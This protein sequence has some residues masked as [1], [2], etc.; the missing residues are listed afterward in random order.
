MEKRKLIWGS[1]K[2]FKIVIFPFRDKLRDFHIFIIVDIFF[3]LLSRFNSSIS[4]L[5]YEYQIPSAL[6]GPL[7]IFMD[8]KSGGKCNCLF[9]TFPIGIISV[10]LRF[11]RRPEYFSKLLKIAIAIDNECKS[12]RNRVVS[13]AIKPIFCSISLI[14]IPFMSLLSLI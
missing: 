8:D 4:F 1:I 9:L 7:T 3:N 12:A 11:K 6:K 2:V 10:L 13:S 5:L 14:L